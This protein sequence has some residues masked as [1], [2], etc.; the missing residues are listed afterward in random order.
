VAEA[1]DVSLATAKRH[2]ARA[3]A[4]LHAIVRR[5]PI[6]AGYLHAASTRGASRGCRE[7]AVH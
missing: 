7:A 2:L 5:E 3:S 1:I 4:R 6:L